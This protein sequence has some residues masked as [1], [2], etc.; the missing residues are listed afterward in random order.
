MDPLGDI[1]Q[2]FWLTRSMARTVGVS[3]GD[4]VASGLLPPDEYS[5]MVTRC[6]QSNCAKRCADWLGAQADGQASRPPQFCAHCDQLSA[7]RPI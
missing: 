4:A 5:R 3:L 1:E 7:L 6:R 2:H